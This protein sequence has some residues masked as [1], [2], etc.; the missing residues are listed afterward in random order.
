[1]NNL[2]SIVYQTLSGEIQ[3]KLNQDTETFWIT[4]Q[5]M[6]EIFEIDRSVIT[7]HIN[8]LF[9][10][11]EITTE[12]NV[13]KMHVPN[14]DKPV[15]FYSLDVILAVWY[16]TNSSKAIKF[17]QRATQTLKQH[18]TQWYTINPERI[19]H[20]YDQFLKA[21]EEIKSLALPNTSLQ[22][23]DILELIS[24]FS[25][26]WFSLDAYDKSL[27]QLSD[28][29]LE[30]INLEAQ[31][32]YQDVS[33]LKQDLMIKWEASDLFAQEKNSGSL[34]GILGNIFQTAFGQEVYPSIESK[35][36]HLLYFVIKNHPFNDGNKRTWAFAFIR[37]LRK[38]KYPFESKIT[39]QALTALALLIAES[40]P[41]DKDKIAA[42]VMLLLKQ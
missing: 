4:Q 1:M 15:K 21:V 34:E 26:T 40:D 33:L 6:A 30:T 27:L 31:K 37:L 14:S 9:K 38:A 29:T 7:K 5:Q 41:H 8:K 16:K 2:Q 35:A 17:R 18:I 32:L 12:S 22:A 20:N 3:I 42:L 19:K 28:Y 13:Q 39:P 24:S 10:D 36:S 25:P 23:N 11:N